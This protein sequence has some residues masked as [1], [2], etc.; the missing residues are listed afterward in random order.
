MKQ[1]REKVRIIVDMRRSGINGMMKVFERVVLPRV[2]DVASALKELLK[3][4]RVG[5]TP[6]FYIIDFSDAF[7]TLKL[8]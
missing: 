2:S 7:Y 8:Q 3:H 5:E 6:E 4:A 1:G